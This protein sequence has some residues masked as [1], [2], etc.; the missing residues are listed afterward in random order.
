MEPA[1][2]ASPAS[3]GPWVTLAQ[4]QLLRSG[5]FPRGG[6]ARGISDGRLLLTPDANARA[7]ALARIRATGATVVR[8]GVDWHDW[9]D[10]HPPAGFDARDP[11]SP[12]YRFERVDAAVRDAVAAGEQPLLV[13]SH[14]P[15]FAEAPHRWAYA[16]GGSWAPDPAALE[17]FATALARRYDGSFPDPLAPG[18]SLPRVSMFQAWNEPNLA[19]YLEPQWVVQNGHWSAFSPLLYRQ[20]LNAFYAGVKSVQPAALVVAAGVA[21]NGE[22]DGQGR[23]AP[24]RFL[25]G[26]LCLS[27]GANHPCADPPHFDVLSF[28]PLSVGDPDV[29]ASSSLNVSIADTSKVTSLLA[30]ARRRHTALPDGPK[31]VWVTELNWTSA[32]SSSSSTPLSSTDAPPSSSGVPARLQAR[33]VSRA[34]HRLWVAGVGLVDWQFLVDP[35]PALKLAGPLGGDA[36]ALSRPAGLYSAGAGGDPAAALPKAF[37]HGFTFPFDPLRVDRKHVRVW[38]LLRA[39]AQRVVLQ[40]QAHDRSWHTLARLHADRHG[41]LNVL[42]RL[43]GSARLRLR[44]VGLSSAPQSVSGRRVAL[45]RPGASGTLIKRLARGGG[46]AEQPM[47]L[48]R[49]PER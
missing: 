43:T 49:A 4:D 32:P 11:A 17:A 42:V 14:A 40:R 37:L 45:P 41:V 28:H 10:A 27:A 23:M 24:L 29:P 30:R 3:T 9:V 2:G 19:R 13:V 47:R 22:P 26:M 20:L 5:P 1:T 8:V 21:P 38:G 36:V 31:P 44:S 6:L 15:A 16:Y 7:L 34:L 18:R 12:S 25:E 35:Y 46:G 48:V 39:R 33:W